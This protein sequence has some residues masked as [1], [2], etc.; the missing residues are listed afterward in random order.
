MR[1]DNEPLVDLDELASLLQRHEGPPHVQANARARRPRRTPRLR[2]GIAIAAA[3]LLAGSGLGFGIASSITPESTA[4]TSPDGLGFI[5]LRGWTVAQ[6]GTA[7]PAGRATAIAANVPLRAGDGLRGLPRRTLAAL[8]AGGVLIHATFSPRGDPEEDARFPEQSL[9]L[10][11]ADAKL[12]QP[13]K[14]PLALGDGVAQHRL[15]AGVSGYNV[16]ARIFY[17]SPSPS[18]AML[19]AAQRQLGK[20][21][22]SA[23]QMTIFARP[24]VLAAP[25]NHVLT[26]FGTVDNG[27]AGELVD[28]QAKDCGQQFFRGVAGTTTGD[29]GRY[30]VQYDPLVTTTVRAVS[31]GKASAAVKVRHLAMV[32]MTRLPRKGQVF[33]IG[34]SGKWTFW[35]KRVQVQQRKSGRWTTIR[36][37]LLTESGQGPGISG[38]WGYAK[39]SVPRGTRLRAVVSKSQA[40]P[41]YSAATSGVVKVTR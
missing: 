6:A 9:P 35:H 38:F 28:I 1:A 3:A 23:E 14:S 18:R 27:K 32:G 40:K 19:G 17:G 22:V 41:C 25:P 37:V 30:E 24:T 10:D 36:S 34:V 26:L 7:G 5:P 12:V 8:P 31:D 29:G 39:L 11:L 21:V 4:G 16:D 15:R 13:E 33:R 2:R 20:L